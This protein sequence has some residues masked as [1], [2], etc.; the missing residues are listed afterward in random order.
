MKHIEENVAK[1]NSGV[2]TNNSNS[3]NGIAYM[4]KEWIMPVVVAFLIVIFLNRFIFILVKVPTPSMEDTIMVGDRLYI[5]ELFDI[6]DAQRGDILVFKSDELEE[7]RLVKRLIG[8]PGDVV[9]VEADGTV[10]INGEKLDEPYAAKA[11]IGKMMFNVPE[12]SYLFL[13]DNRPVS[14]DAR[15]WENPYINGDKIIGKVVF[16]FFPFSRIGK[17]K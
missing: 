6:K 4:F 17:V 8:L 14:K 5:N 3:P 16:R 11:G 2:G 7:K 15:Y 9:E 13:G 10:F 1:K 12:N